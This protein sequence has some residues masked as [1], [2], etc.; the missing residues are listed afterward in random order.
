[1]EKLKIVGMS[2]EEYPEGRIDTYRIK[3][4]EEYTSHLHIIP[5]FLELGFPKEIV[6]ERLDTIYEI[7]SEIFIYGNEKIKAWIF[8]EDGLLSIK[9]DTSLPREEINKAVE[10]YFEFPKE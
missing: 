1:M 3:T 9:F 4:Q 8:V 10:K 7:Q 5:L 6:N 2:S